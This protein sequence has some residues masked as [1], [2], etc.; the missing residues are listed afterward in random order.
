MLFGNIAAE[1]PV[2]TVPQLAV[3][4]PVP[5]ATASPQA[6]GGCLPAEASSWHFVASTAAAMRTAAPSVPAVTLLQQP[7]PSFRSITDG[8]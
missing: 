7:Q 5:T 6:L 8:D 3:F 1:L 2:C 4:L